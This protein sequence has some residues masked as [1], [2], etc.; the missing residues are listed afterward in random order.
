MYE[1]GGSMF[2]TCGPSLLY[3]KHGAGG[4]TET[5]GVHGAGG[6]YHS[7]QHVQNELKHASFEGA[8]EDG[9][10]YYSEV[11]RELCGSYS[12]LLRYEVQR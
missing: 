8:C 12:G 2:L 5:I 4:P 9:P 11:M 6:S 1:C 7:L 10:E 3:F